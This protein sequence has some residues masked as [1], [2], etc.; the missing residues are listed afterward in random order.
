MVSAGIKKVSSRFI[1][2]QT[3]LAGVH[4]SH[5]NSDKINTSGAVFAG[6]FAKPGC[7]IGP[8]SMITPSK[9]AW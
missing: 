1:N 3:I 7:A 6:V 8:P 9:K 2:I 5:E 4:E